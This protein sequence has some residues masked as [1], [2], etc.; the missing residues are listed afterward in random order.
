MYLLSQT[1]SN[2]FMKQQKRVNKIHRHIANQRNDFLHK[3][4]TEIANRYDVVAVEDLNMRSLSNKGFGNGKATMD[5]GYGMFLNMLEY[6]LNSRG[7]YFV[8]VDRFY[9]SS[10]TCHACGCVNPDVKDLSIRKWI[11]PACGAIHDRDINAAVNIRDEGLRL[12][13]LT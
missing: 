13:G 4:S 10:Q 12:L 1:K 5:N 11:C 9:P 2:N 3:T 7:K 8:K 6:K